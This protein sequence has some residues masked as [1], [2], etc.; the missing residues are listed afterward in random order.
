M[1]IC[2]SCGYEIREG[3][4]HQSDGDGRCQ[5]VNVETEQVV[6]WTNRRTRDLYK[7]K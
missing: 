4:K 7:K 3:K 6:G 1:T 5:I 2:E